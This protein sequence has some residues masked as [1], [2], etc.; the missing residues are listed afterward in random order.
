MDVDKETKK[1]Y[2]QTYFKK[3]EKKLKSRMTCPVC[4]TE[5]TVYNYSNHQKT[6]N[7]LLYLS[8]KELLKNI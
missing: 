4:G 5:I 1:K 3:Y 2:N 8:I 7:H 6:Q